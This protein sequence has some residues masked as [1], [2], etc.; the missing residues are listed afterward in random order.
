MAALFT[1]AGYGRR[2]NEGVMPVEPGMSNSSQNCCIWIGS[3]PDRAK[4][5][6]G[7]DGGS[8][9]R[10]RIRS[11]SKLRNHARRAGHE[12]QSTGL[13]HLDGF[14]SRFF[15]KEKRCRWHLFLFGAGYG[16]RTRLHGLGNIKAGSSIYSQNRKKCSICN[17]FSV[18]SIE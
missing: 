5:K 13:L 12:Q 10:S 4:K 11:S 2:V 15:Q 14:D 18:F 9:Y 6:R 7:A 16:S 8:F 1:G 17:G 3:T